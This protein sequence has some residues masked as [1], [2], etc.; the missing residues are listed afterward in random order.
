MGA[1]VDSLSA[2]AF[3]DAVLLWP[4]AILLHVVEE[5]PGFPH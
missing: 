1:I 4:V 5:W 3:R 2:L